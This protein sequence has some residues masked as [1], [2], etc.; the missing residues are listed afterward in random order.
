MPRRK[1]QTDQPDDLIT[2]ILRVVVVGLLVFGTS[3]AAWWKSI[4]T[5]IQVALIVLSIITL[6]AGVGLI[7]LWATY[8]RRQRALVWQRALADWQS[9]SPAT[10]LAGPPQTARYLS[11]QQLETFAAKT[12]KQMGYTVRHTGRMGDHGV[13]VHLTNPQG[14]IE[15]VQCKQW[16][17]PVGEPEIRDFYGAMGHVGAIRG[18][19]WAPNGFSQRAYTWAK[20]KP[21]ELLDEKRIQR[22]IESAYASKDSN[23][24]TN[25]NS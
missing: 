8:K 3:I 1:R 6:L 25:V 9:N 12:Y 15:L 11:P 5:W 22:L 20:G 16:N 13:D 24:P 7:I 17:K 18:W 23:R 21:I 10:S 2:N 19:L 4:P 14:H